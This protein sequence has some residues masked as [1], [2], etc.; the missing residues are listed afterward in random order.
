MIFEIPLTPYHDF[1]LFST[2]TE[3][4]AMNPIGCKY[5]L[6]KISL[7]PVATRELIQCF[8]GCTRVLEPV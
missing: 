3:D 6:F 2:H 5:R 1:R 7:S 4:T 8:L